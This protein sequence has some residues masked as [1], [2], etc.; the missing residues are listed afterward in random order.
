MS[1]HN[2]DTWLLEMPFMP[3]ALT[4]SSTDRIRMP[5]TSSGIGLEPVAARC[6]TRTHRRQRSPALSDRWHS[7]AHPR[8]SGAAPGKPEKQLP[9]HSFGMRNPTVPARLCQSLSRQ[10]LRCTSR[11]GVVPPYP[12]PVS[13]T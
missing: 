2:R 5:C 4:R 8:P 9:L 13:V 3:I 12:A 10:P 1:P 7:R 6:R 11:P